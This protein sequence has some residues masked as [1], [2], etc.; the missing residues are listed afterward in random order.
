MHEQVIVQEI[1]QAPLPC[2]VFT[3]TYRFGLV[4]LLVSKSELDLTVDCVVAFT[5]PFEFGLTGLS[6]LFPESELDLTVDFGTCVMN[7]LP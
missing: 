2:F 4:S 6:L 1:P 5:D 3:D 7:V